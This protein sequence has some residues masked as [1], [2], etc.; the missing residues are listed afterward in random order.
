V[1]SISSEDIG[2]NTCMDSEGIFLRDDLFDGTNKELS[3][4]VN[5][6]YTQKRVFPNGEVVYPEITLYHVSEAYFK[7]MKSY[8]FANMN[9]GNPFAEPTNV[10]TNVTNGFGIFSIQSIDIREIK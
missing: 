10:Y 2:Q 7:Y 5:T 6:M 9:N 1:E 8:M 3:L 4:F